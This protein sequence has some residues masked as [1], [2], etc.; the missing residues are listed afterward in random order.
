MVSMIC[1]R[2]LFPKILSSL[3]RAVKFHTSTD[4][5]VTCTLI[6]GDGVGPEIMDSVQEVLQ[7]MG[8]K[9]NFE[10]ICLSEVQKTNDFS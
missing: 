7:S 10:E 2:K 1:G 4:G 9:I 3:Q 5:H 8:A 6:P